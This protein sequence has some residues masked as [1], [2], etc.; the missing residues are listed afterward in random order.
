MNINIES[1]EINLFKAS[2]IKDGDI[3]L[4]KIDSDQK[5]EFNKENITNLY[6]QIKDL[7]KKDIGIYFFPKNITVEAIK[8]HI[9]SFEENKQKLIVEKQEK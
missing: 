7:V 3:I 1:L 5:K 6:T 8:N 9:S 4:I 2:E